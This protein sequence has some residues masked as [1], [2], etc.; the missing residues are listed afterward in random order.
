MLMLSVIITRWLLFAVGIL[1]EFR[2][3]YNRAHV[4]CEKFNKK[5]S[6][7]NTRSCAKP[8]DSLNFALVQRLRCNETNRTREKLALLPSQSY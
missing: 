8:G 2:E 1:S 5:R 4:I 7:N 6:S 3:Y